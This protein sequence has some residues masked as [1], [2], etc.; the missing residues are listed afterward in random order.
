MTTLSIPRLSETVP[1]KTK[2]SF[3][4]FSGYDKTATVGGVIS[5][6]IFSIVSSFLFP[7]LSLAT[8]EMDVVPSSFRLATTV[9]V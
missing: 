4:A 7:N 3:V 9:P 1:L 6:I 5:T 8:I 2:L